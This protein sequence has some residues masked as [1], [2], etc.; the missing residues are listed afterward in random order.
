M[1]AAAVTAGMVLAEVQKGAAKFAGGTSTIEEMKKPSTT[2]TTTPAPMTKTLLT[3]SVALSP[4]ALMVESSTPMSTSQPQ[5]G[6]AGNWALRYSAL[7]KLAT[8]GRK[9]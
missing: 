4:M 2:R 5:M 1:A 8:M 7:T 6:T 3:T 9:T